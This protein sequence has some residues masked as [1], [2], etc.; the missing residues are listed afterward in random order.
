[1]RTCGE[2]MTTRLVVCEPTANIREVARQM[3]SEDVGPIPVVEDKDSK[4]LVGIVTDR[5]L[6]LKV[7]AEGRDPSSTQVREVM[8][9]SPVTCHERDNLDKALRAMEQ[10][11]VRRILVVD[12]SDHLVGIIAQADIATRASD[13]KR[14]GDLVEKISKPDDTQVR[15]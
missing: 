5:D 13:D 2:V 9:P 10:H 7:L 6:V 4:R 1:M 11:Q 3:K 15:R 14:T 8:T 12:D